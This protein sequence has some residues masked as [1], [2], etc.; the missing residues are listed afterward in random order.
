MTLTVD[1]PVT[2][3]LLASAARAVGATVASTGDLTA[4]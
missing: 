1:N 2:P 3:E 4:D